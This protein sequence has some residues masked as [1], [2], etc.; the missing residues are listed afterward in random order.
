MDRHLLCTFCS[1]YVTISFL[2]SV[3]FLYFH[4][5]GLDSQEWDFWVE[6]N[7]FILISHIYEYIIYIVFGETGWSFNLGLCAYK[8]D[9]LLA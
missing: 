3:C 2:A 5:Y 9:T 6:E 7:V 4:F 8:T 1:N